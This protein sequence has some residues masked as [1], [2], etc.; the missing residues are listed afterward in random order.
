M[1]CLKSVLSAR[2]R[3]KGLDGVRELSVNHGDKGTIEGK[4]LTAVM[5]KMNSCEMSAIIDKQNIISIATF[6]NK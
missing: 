5:H 4:Q 6:G 3:P 2:I 1:K